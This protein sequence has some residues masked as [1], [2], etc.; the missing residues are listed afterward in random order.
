VNGPAISANGRTMAV[1]WFT[2]ASGQGHSYAA[3]SPDAGRTWGAPIR[4]DAQ[5]STGR[6]DIEMLADGT[7]VASWVE[8]SN[9]QAQ[10]KARRVSSSGSPSEAVAVQ[11]A[12]GGRAAGF[13]R[14]TRQGQ[15]LVF[16][17]VEGGEEG[18]QIKGAVAQVN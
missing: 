10:F 8:F 3:F 6:V 14:M 18:G 4:L 17:W 7:A 9:Q 15:E 12:A 16:V 13:P 2:A 5:A 11:G 1:A